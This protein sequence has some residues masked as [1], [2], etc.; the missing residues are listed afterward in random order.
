MSA[1][2]DLYPADVVTPQGRF[3]KARLRL[4]DGLARVF[5]APRGYV[6]LAAE[7]SYTGFASRPY[8]VTLSDGSEWEARKVGSCGCHSALK[9]F[10]PRTWGQ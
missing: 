3:R 2:L 4:E 8:K 9:K 10:D 6:E 7:S 1:A 5:I